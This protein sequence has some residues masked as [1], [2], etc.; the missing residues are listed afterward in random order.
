MKWGIERSKLVTRMSQ[1]P[2]CGSVIN[3]Q[4]DG[5]LRLKYNINWNWVRNPASRRSFHKASAKLNGIQQRLVKELYATGV[6]TCHIDELFEDRGMWR[7]LSAEMAAFNSSEE[8]QS[9][10]RKRQQDFAQKQDFAAVEHYIISKYPQDRTPLISADNP[11]LRFGLHP[12]VLDVV[13]SYL[14]LWSKMIYFDMWHTLPLSTDKRFSSQCWHRDPEDRRKIRTFLYFGKVDANAGAMEYFLGS[15]WGGPY[16]HVLRWSDPVRM[17][18]PTDG[19][20]ERQIPASQRM[21]LEGSAGTLI[22]CDTAGFHR[23]GIAKTIPRILATSA[24]VTP[25]SLHRR[26]YDIDASVREFPWSAP[27]KFAVS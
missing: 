13:N 16:E 14:G 10:V 17:Q 15:H 18:Y 2:G 1:I 12:L 4:Y 23:G 22:F 6:A 21:T 9:L 5:L 26:R 27:A 19:E 20:V 7:S 11:L 25:A 3:R 8:V 24:Y